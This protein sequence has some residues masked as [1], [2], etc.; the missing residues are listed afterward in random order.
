MKNEM[1]VVCGTCGG[2]KKCFQG[3]GGESWEKETIWKTQE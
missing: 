2:E 3:F 1:G